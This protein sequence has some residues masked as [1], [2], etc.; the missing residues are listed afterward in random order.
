GIPLTSQALVTPDLVHDFPAA[1]FLMFFAMHLLVV[2]SACYLTFG[3]RIVPTWRDFG[4]TVAV[5]WVWAV[6]VVCFNLV[7]GANYG[8]LNGK[9]NDPSILDLF[10]PWPLYVLF[11]VAVILTVWALMV[12]PWARRAR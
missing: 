12:W 2:W 8:Y 1:R 9:P 10:G 7:T 4:L 5:T 3:L 6:G 11:E